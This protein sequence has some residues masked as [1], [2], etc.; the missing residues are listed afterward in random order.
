MVVGTCAL[1]L[2]HTIDLHCSN[3][4]QLTNDSPAPIFTINILAAAAA[5]TCCVRLT[6]EK[7]SHAIFLFFF[8]K[9]KT[10]RPKEIRPRQ[11]TW[12]ANSSLGET[13]R[14]TLFSLHVLTELSL[15]S[16]ILIPSI[17][18]FQERHHQV[19]HLHNR[20]PQ[21]CQT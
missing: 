9:S 17:G 20:K 8:L 7:L 19:H 6:I 11:Q 18:P 16:L 4:K 15:G 2:S 1:F 14:C 5:A 10:C 13:S 3:P 21:Q 12:R